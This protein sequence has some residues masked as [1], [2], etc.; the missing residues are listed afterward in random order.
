M[1][2]K[3]IEE[4]E[5]LYDKKVKSLVF[6]GR[7]DNIAYQINTDEHKYLLKI[8]LGNNSKE[9]IEYELTWLLALNNDTQLV[10]QTPIYNK[11]GKLVSE[12]SGHD[13]DISYWTL[14][15]WVYGENLQRQPT[16]KELYG[17]SDLLA[18]LHNHA[19]T[20]KLPPNFIRPKYDRANL[21]ESLI[22]IATLPSNVIS[23]EQIATLR[24]T[25]EKIKSVIA[26]QKLNENT[27]GIIH[28]D[29]HDGNYLIKDEVPYAIDFSCCGFGFFLFDIAETF[30]HLN[31]ENQKKLMTYYLKKR[32]LQED[33][34]EVL[35]AFF[36]WQIIR[37]LSFLSKSQNEYE[38]ITQEIPYVIENFCIKYLNQQRFLLY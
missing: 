7:S 17:V 27:W 34:E 32:T 3:I 23:L 36:I 19:S 2:K 33:Y 28:S 9:M 8:H 20:W 24:R 6:L 35:E 13:Y 37:N 12:V 30:L 31:P 4:L 15:N 25:T 22:Q 11:K 14:Q 5:F 26:K 29:L 21:D 10:V 16:D 18:S 38:F 1:E